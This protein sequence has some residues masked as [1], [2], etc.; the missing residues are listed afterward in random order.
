MGF[1]ALDD[2]RAA[3]TERLSHRR[4]AV[5]LADAAQIADTL[6]GGIRDALRRAPAIGGDPHT[7]AGKGGG[8]AKPVCRFED[9]DGR[10]RARGGERRGQTRRSRSDHDDASLLTGHARYSF[11]GLRIARVR[12]RI[13]HARVGRLENKIAIITGGAAGIGRATA[14][15]MA[16]E[17]ASVVIADING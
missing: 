6:L 2:T 10:T 5:A 8:A 11:V 17:G 9:G 13:Y 16:E 12:S 7:A 3:P 15:R 1:D 14:L 4:I